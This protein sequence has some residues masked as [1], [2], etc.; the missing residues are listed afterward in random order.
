MAW[1][2]MQGE[3]SG[4]SFRGADDAAG[5]NHS[6][7]KRAGKLFGTGKEA[8]K[9]KL[10]KRKKKKSASKAKAGGV[11]SML[12]NRFLKKGAPSTLYQ[13]DHPYGG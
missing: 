13:S 3:T 12:A 8:G 5:E 2:G 10:K 6:K 7:A 11:A 4:D 1:N 9:K